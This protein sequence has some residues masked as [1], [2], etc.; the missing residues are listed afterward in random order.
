[1][2][3]PTCSTD[4]LPRFLAKV[5]SSAGPNGCHTWTGFIDKDG[6]GRFPVGRTSIAAHRWMLQHSV[7]RALRTEEHA[8]HHC[9][10]PPCVNPKHLYVGDHSRNMKDRAARGRY[11]QAPGA[12]KTH[13]H[14]GHVRTPENTYIRPQRGSSQ[15]RDCKRIR[16]REWK[17]KQ[18]AKRAAS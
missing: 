12:T 4:A 11:W 13:C 2:P 18:R 7:G 16:N 3:D 8:L 14:R 6:Y 5:D 15:C 1:M 17:A 9:D 10:N